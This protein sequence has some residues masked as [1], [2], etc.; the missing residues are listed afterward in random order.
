MTPSVEM[1]VGGIVVDADTQSPIVVLRSVTDDRIYLPIFIGTAEATAIAAALADVALPRPMT[2]DLMANL[3]NE[4]GCFVRQVDVTELVDGTFFALVTLADDQGHRYEVDARPSDGVALAL[5]TGA[6]IL[7]AQAV[8]D[9]AGGVVE[10][11]SPAPARPPQ[12][13]AEQVKDAAVGPQPL[14]GA[15][16]RLEDLEEAT[17]GP[18]K[19]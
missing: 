15:D 17:F 1:V 8:L 2:H 10:E 16:V 9:A 13:A 4:I 18:Y 19:M 3:L 12:P 5:R 7:V 11:D 6:R 14:A